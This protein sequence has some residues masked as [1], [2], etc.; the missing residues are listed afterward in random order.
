MNMS[1]Y[2]FFISY[3]RSDGQDLAIQFNKQL[4]EKGYSVFIDIES[5]RAGSDFTQSIIDAISNCDY[6]V[7]IITDATSKSEWVKRDFICF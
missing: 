7:P 3:C 6:F 1:K 5:L 2:N 4:T